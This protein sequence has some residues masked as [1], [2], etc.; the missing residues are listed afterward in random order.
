MCS[1]TVFEIDLQREQR[2]HTTAIIQFS[3]IITRLIHDLYIPAD[4]RY[5]FSIRFCPVGGKSAVRRRN[6]FTLA[7][8]ALFFMHKTV[9]VLLLRS[10]EF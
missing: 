7:A 6:V 2:Y 4:F 5:I 9:Y 10:F 1:F 3:Y 8:D